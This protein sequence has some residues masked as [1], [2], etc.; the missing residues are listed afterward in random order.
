[1]KRK[2]VVFSQTFTE[3]RIR[4]NNTESIFLSK[5]RRTN[6]FYRFDNRIKRQERELL[7]FSSISGVRRSFVRGEEMKAMSTSSSN[8]HN[9]DKF[10]VSLAIRKLQ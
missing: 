1:M 6:S 2:G 3:G 8:V 9:T 4:R 7:L 5:I 10:V